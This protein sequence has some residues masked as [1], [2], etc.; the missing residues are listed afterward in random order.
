MYLGLGVVDIPSLGVNMLSQSMLSMTISVIVYLGIL[1]NDRV[2]H[3][4]L[5]LSLLVR[6]YI[7][8]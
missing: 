3:I 2:L 5:N 1:F 4:L 8:T 6:I 7:S